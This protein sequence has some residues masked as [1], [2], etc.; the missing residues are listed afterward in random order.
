MSKEKRPYRA[1]T[2]N[3]LTLIIRFK[4][5]G[6]LKDFIFSNEFKKLNGEL[7]NLALSKNAKI[8]MITRPKL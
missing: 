2:K 5:E 3:S 4:T 7:A 1:L 6:S 8:E